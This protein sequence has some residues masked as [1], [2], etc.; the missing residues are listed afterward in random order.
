MKDILDLLLKVDVFQDNVALI[1]V[2][3]AR[4][5]V[6]NIDLSQAGGKRQLLCVVSAFCAHVIFFF[7]FTEKQKTS[8]D[9]NIFLVS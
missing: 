9:I 6:A 5:T 4:D 1:I 7:F 2:L 3:E 8:I